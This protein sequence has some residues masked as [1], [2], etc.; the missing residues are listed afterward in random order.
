MD[1]F[2]H[3]FCVTK[4]LQVLFYESQSL[5]LY[6]DSFVPC[7]SQ[8]GEKG[9]NFTWNT[10]LDCTHY[11]WWAQCLFI[12]SG[13][14][15]YQIVRYVF[16]ENITRTWITDC[17]RTAHTRR[18]AKLL[19]QWFEVELHSSWK[20]ASLQLGHSG[21]GDLPCCTSGPAV[22]GK[23]RIIDPCSGSGTWHK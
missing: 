16:L 6:R 12:Q 18:N 14:K 9:A 21:L 13:C 1:I 22:T 19:D 3:V 10:L 11:R 8:S 23:D 17:A 2:V 15:S 7:S 20:M 4:M 5:V